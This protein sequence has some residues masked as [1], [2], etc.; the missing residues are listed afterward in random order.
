M[1][2]DTFYYAD[3]GVV[4]EAVPGDATV[5]ERARIVAEVLSRS[6][7]SYD[8]VEKRAAYR[9][10]APLAAFVVVHGDMRRVEVDERGTGGVW[11]TRTYDAGEA[12]V[13]GRAIA[14][15]TIY[16]RSSLD[17]E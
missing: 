3:A 11:Q 6:T 12:F 15:D 8:L 5:I 2:S 1:A 10:M 14:L 17:L 9:T 16:A 7:R 13:D 4:C